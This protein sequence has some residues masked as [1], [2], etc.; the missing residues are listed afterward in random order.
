M[1]N[2]L[3]N[4]TLV[5]KVLET[6]EG[7]IEQPEGVLDLCPNFFDEEFE[8][9]DATNCETLA[10]LVGIF[11]S[12]SS[13]RKNGFAGPIPFGLSCL[14]TKKKW[15]FVWNPIQDQETTISKGFIKSF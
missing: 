8:V 2:F 7:P 15:F 5:P 3:V 9:I 13:A 6:P 10:V 12:K 14:G 4:N 11:D 1:R